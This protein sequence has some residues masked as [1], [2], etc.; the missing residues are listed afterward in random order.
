MTPQER[1]GTERLLRESAWFRGLPASLR[2]AI[3][4]R[5]VLHGY[6]KGEVIAAQGSPAEGLFAILEGRVAWTRLARPG[7]EVLLYIAGPGAWFGHLALLRDTPYQ[8]KVVAHAPSRLLMLPRAEYQRLVGEDPANFRRIAD[9]ALERLE[10]LIRVYAERHVP[11]EDLIPA[12]LATLAAL[13]RTETLQAGGAIKLA[14]SQAEAAAIF[15][16]ARQTLNGVLKRLESAGLV[17]VGFRQLVIPDA[18]R[19]ARAVAARAG[20]ARRRPREGG[21]A[22]R[23]AHP[24]SGDRPRRTRGRAVLQRRRA[25][26]GRR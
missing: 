3:L 6:P 14:L 17:E 13:R 8:F 22:S 4:D 26:T 7:A 11:A 5:S 9:T 23:D 15:G 19:L 18:A 24:A 10:L 12:R 20:P 1:E 16:V 25:S 21:H 2:D